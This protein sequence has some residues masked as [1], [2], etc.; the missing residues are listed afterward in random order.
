MKKLAILVM[1]VVMVAGVEM[2]SAAAPGFLDSY[3]KAQAQAK[4]ENKPLYLHFTTSWCKWCRTIENDI[5]KNPAGK[6]ALAGFV[7][8]S[9]DCTTPR[10][11]APTGEAKINIDLMKKFGGG[12]YPFLVMTTPDGVVLDKISGY[13]PIDNFKEVL[14]KAEAKFKKYQEFQVYAAKADKKSLEYNVKALEMYSDI[15]SWGK[16]AQAAVAL[17]KL[18]PK[19]EKVDPAKV[20]YALYVQAAQDPKKVGQKKLRELEQAVFKADPDNEKGYME[21]VC[22][23][24]ALLLFQTAR[25]TRSQQGQKVILQ[26]MAVTLTELTK[27]AKKLKYGENVYSLLG[28]AYANLGEFDK[29]S[30]TYKKLLKMVPEGSNRAK[31]IAETLEKLKQAKAQQQQQEENKAAKAELKKKDAAEPKKDKSK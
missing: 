28:F 1:A 16:A 27:K 31:E 29:A 3:A 21:K 6:K 12:G 11:T 25:R 13:K 23:A 20:N 9:L 5:Y 14:A 30:A 19:G 10:G 17:K 18:D 4:K 15:G 22:W 8:A 7:C 24:K 2:A 26:Q